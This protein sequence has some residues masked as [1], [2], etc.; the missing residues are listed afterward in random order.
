VSEQFL[1]KDTSAQYRLCSASLDWRRRLGC[2]R[3]TWLPTLEADLQPLKHELNSAWQLAR[4]R[5]R[6]RQLVET[7]T[8][9]SGAQWWWCVSH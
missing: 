1:N 6:W 2:P 4:N 8:L 3:H 5:G 9:Q 7:T